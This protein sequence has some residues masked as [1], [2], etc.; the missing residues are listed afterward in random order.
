MQVNNISIF[1]NTYRQFK[2]SNEKKV[3]MIERL[4]SERRINRAADD[5]N[6]LAI[7]E[8][9]RGQIRGLNQAYRNVLDGYSLLQTA[10]GVLEEG[11]SILQR[12]REIAV[13]AGNDTKKNSVN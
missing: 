8:K 2:V 3:R 6:G 7:L 12:M 1:L 11:H 4:S 10:D 5:P 13:Q 9:M